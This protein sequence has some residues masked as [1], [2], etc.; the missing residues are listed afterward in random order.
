M[1][2][3]PKALKD[4][5]MRKRT[6]GFLPLL[7]LLLRDICTVS[8]YRHIIWIETGKRLTMYSMCH[9]QDSLAQHHLSLKKEADK[10][11]QHVSVTV[12]KI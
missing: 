6:T 9:C 1:C 5:I 8:Y 3:H 4:I 7:L 10:K 2:P 12:F 11:C